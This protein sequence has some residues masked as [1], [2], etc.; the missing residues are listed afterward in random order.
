MPQPENRLASYVDQLRQLRQAHDAA[1]AGNPV[2]T[3]YVAPSLTQA[4]PIDPVAYAGPDGIVRQSELQ[5]AHQQV[6]N[7]LANAPM[8][9]GATGE[10]TG[11]APADTLYHGTME[12]FAGSPRPSP[13][14]GFT[15]WTPSR[16][17]AENYGMNVHER[18]ADGLNLVRVK[19]D[20][21]SPHTC[22]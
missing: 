7:A 3:S 10:G 21:L 2:G 17:W 11:S 18:P 5:G 16:D 13:S 12:S 15:W 20:S 9:L 19:G 22:A 6:Q 14:S 8:I 4:T 1:W